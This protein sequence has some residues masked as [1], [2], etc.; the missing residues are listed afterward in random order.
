MGSQLFLVRGERD[1][2]R[3]EELGRACRL[4]EALC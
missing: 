3:V 2:T 1:P 4:I